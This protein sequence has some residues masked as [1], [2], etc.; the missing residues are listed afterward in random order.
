MFRP[1]LAGLLAAGLVLVAGLAGS[2][3]QEKK[4]DKKD[5]PKKKERIAVA[6]PKDAAKDPDFAIQGEYEG[7][8][9]LNSGE[10]KVGAHVIAKGLSTKS[11]DDG[12]RI[13]PVDTRPPPPVTRPHAQMCAS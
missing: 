12:P 10:K 2:T 6:E 4:D 1:L 3:A 7:S 9:K 13:R 11:P 5:P 8:I